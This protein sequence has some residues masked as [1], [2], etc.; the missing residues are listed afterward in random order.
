MGSRK[1]LADALQP[2]LGKA[3]KV[4]DA[5]REIEEIEARVKAVVQLV[6]TKIKPSPANP[7]G[8]YE[9]S[10]EIW[11]I[12]PKLDPNTSEDALDDSLDKV[13]LAL[14][15]LNW[16]DYDEAIR[17]THPSDRHA[18]RITATLYTEKE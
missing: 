10:F 5:P 6:R 3:V 9:E 16:I 4:V 15:S 2:A 12:E 11:V 7:Q 1:Q 8:D 14:D 17:D 13:L 18:Y